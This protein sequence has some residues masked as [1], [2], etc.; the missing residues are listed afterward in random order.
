MKFSF[1]TN[2]LTVT[3]GGCGIKDINIGVQTK[4]TMHMK[5]D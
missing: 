5:K 4:L 1:F 2:V 3:T